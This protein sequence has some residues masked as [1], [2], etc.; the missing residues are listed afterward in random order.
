VDGQY[1]VEM[2]LEA[3][4]AL[5]LR[6]AHAQA[7][8]LEARAR[9]EITNLAEIT[10]HIEPRGQLA[11][12]GDPPASDPGD[13]QQLL[14]QV[15]QVALATLTRGALHEVQARHSQRGWGVTLHY[16]LPGDIELAEAHAMSMQLERR[17]RER[18]PALQRVVIH[19]EPR[20]AE[21]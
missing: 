17:L 5:P 8:A 4:G 16:S 1:T 14:Q 12:A 9:A 6:Q 10:T 3:D 20:D 21:G 19:T 18:I 15:R 2:H 11:P 13:E 7:S